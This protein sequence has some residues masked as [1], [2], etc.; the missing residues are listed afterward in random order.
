MN[1]TEITIIKHNIQNQLT[2]KQIS[3]LFLA[4]S[5]GT[6]KSTAIRQIA[7]ELDFNLIEYSCPTISVEQITG[8]PNEYSTPSFN[9]AAI[10]PTDIDVVSTVWTIPEI[11]AKVWTAS[12][13]K[14]TIL[15]LDDFH[16]IAPHLQTYFYSLLLDHRIGNYRL[17]DNAVIV[18]TMN[19]SEAAGFKGI[20][21]AVRNRMSILK[22]EFD[23]DY[24]VKSFGN[25]LHYLVA[26][27]LKAKP[28]YTSEPETTTIQG[29][30]TARA[31]TAIAAEL[32][33]H[34]P[35]FIQSNSGRIAGMQVS[36]EAAKAFQ[37]H[38]MYV[39]NIDFTNLVKTKTVVDL[40]TKD[41][42]DTIIYSYITNFINTPEDGK[43]LFELME[44]NNN[45]A[46][47]QF[48]GFVLG[49]LYIKF[50]HETQDKPISDGIRY[51]IDTLLDQPINPNNYI[52]PKSLDKVAKF[53]PANLN[54]FGTLAH[55]YLL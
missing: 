31:W 49:E 43:Y 9:Q 12:K 51:V 5:P 19:G 55:E 39:A 20:G 32:D 30:A 38:V 36:P 46:S 34:T 47:S 33:N 52:K 3:P 53:K 26:S 29:Y 11:L 1:N 28:H 18:G 17:P 45:K 48:I 37:T 41:P 25:R 15:L 54:Q 23:F 7:A 6:G 24:W 8:L 4:G 22:I 35:E 10:T 27:F 44:A 40:S 16:E 50:T 14:P 2:N 13:T 42:L 21:S